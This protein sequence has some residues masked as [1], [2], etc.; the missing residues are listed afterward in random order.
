MDVKKL[1][2]YFICCAAIYYTAIS[3]VIMIVNVALLSTDS[4]K[5]IVPEQF[6]FLLMFSGFMALGSTLRKIDVI[7]SYIAWVL[8]ATCYVLGFFIFALCCKMSPTSSLLLTA[9]FS[10]IYA[11]GAVTVGLVEKR[12]GKHT[13]SVSA[14]GGKNKESKNNK[15]AIKKKEKETYTSMFS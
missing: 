4:T 13:V 2:K 5:V 8:N 10:I 12:R 7:R 14:Q 3:T 15:K 6:L 11:A 1:L 9:A